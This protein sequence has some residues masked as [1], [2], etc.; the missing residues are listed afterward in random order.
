MPALDSK[1]GEEVLFTETEMLE[2]GLLVGLMPDVAFVVPL[3]SPLI[4]MALI[5][6]SSLKG[7][8]L[9]SLSLRKQFSWSRLFG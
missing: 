5:V 6:K 1:V 9:M 7:C 2:D 3:G 4:R 8:S